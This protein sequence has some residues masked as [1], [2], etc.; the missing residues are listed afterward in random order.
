MYM[1]VL[2]KM[3]SR[4]KEHLKVECRILNKKLLFRKI[5]INYY[6]LTKMKSIVRQKKI[7]IKTICVFYY[8][9]SFYINYILHFF[10]RVVRDIT[11]KRLKA[12]GE[13]AASKIPAKAGIP[14]IASSSHSQQ[15]TPW[16]A[17]VP[18]ASILHNSIN[19]ARPVDSDSDY[20]DSVESDFSKPVQ[21]EAESVSEETRRLVSF[22]SFYA[23][24]LMLNCCFF[25]SVC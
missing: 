20:N 15:K 5:I 7:L 14:R 10:Q 21:H 16:K 19:P 9:F 1:Y 17:P 22:R 11:L 4:E 23:T 8:I 2:I 12:T 24:N 25:F 18:M 6:F 3:L 13:T